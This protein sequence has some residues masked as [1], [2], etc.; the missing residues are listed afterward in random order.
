MEIKVACSLGISCHS[1]NL[2]KINKLLECSY[3]F[4]WI[5]TSPENVIH[6]IEDGFNKFLDKSYYKTVKEKVCSHSLYHWIMF[7]HHNPLLDEKDYKYFID[8]V[9]RFNFY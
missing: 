4:D 7:N 3:P 5:H 6:C 9:N 2:L 8:C 1:S